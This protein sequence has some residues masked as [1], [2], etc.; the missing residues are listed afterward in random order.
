MLPATESVHS[1]IKTV[2]EAVSTVPA[3]LESLQQDI[4]EIPMRTLSLFKQDDDYLSEK[5]KNINSTENN[6]LTMKELELQDKCSIMIDMAGRLGAEKFISVIDKF[7]LAIVSNAKRIYKRFNRKYNKSGI[8]DYKIKQQ[9]LDI[10]ISIINAGPVADIKNLPR[11]YYKEHIDLAY[12]A[13][14]QTY[15][16][17]KIFLSYIQNGK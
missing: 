7:T 11:S 6:I 12:L 17:L 1:S 5:D 4:N 9:C 10:L 16:S 8:Y 13:V 2:S 14:N 15:R 3:Q